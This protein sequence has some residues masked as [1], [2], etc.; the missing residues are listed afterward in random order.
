MLDFFAILPTYRV[1]SARFSLRIAACIVCA[2]ALLVSVFA[3]AGADTIPAALAIHKQNELR[4][5]VIGDSITAGVI[6]GTHNSD[7][8]G[9]RGR[10]AQ[11]L[12]ANGYHAVFV[13]SRSDYAGHAQGLHHEGYP[14][15]VIR[16]TSKGA[17]GQLLGP[18]VERALTNYDPDVILLMA[19]TNDLLKYEADRDEHGPP[20]PSDLSPASARPRHPR[21]DR[22]QSP[23][24]GVHDRAL[25]YRPL[26]VHPGDLRES[27]IVGRSVFRAR[28]CDTIRRHAQRRSA[29]PRSLSRR[30]PPRARRLCRPG[31][32]LVQGDPFDHRGQ[33]RDGQQPLILLFKQGVFRGIASSCKVKERLTASKSSTACAA[34]RYWS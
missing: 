20:A 15:Y 1:M 26:D 7:E 10:L 12:A 8:G 27:A 28:V 24:P 30:D 4:I 34:S 29:R 31:G 19:G 3:S 25:R 14:G 6:D 16:A 13:G 9:Y 5:M 11:L 18:I 22:K 33:R 21:R 32:R 17:P 23:P 2:A